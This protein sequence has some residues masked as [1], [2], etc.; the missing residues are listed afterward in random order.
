MVTHSPARR[1][2]GGALVPVGM[3]LLTGCT[4][5]AP[6]PSG[7]DT[8]T[9]TTQPSQTSDATSASSSAAGIGST[10]PSP[11]PTSVRKDPNAPANQCATSDL[12]VSVRENEDGNGLSHRGFFVALRN[13]GDTECELRGAPGVSLVGRGDGTQLGAA[14][15]RTEV[16]I[17]PT[18]EV[19]PGGYAVALL[20]TEEMDAHG[21]IFADGHGDD[22]KC[23]VAKADGYRI[24]PPH[25]Y[26]AVFV[27]QSGLY[28]CTT[29]VHW[30]SIA[31]V[32]PANRVNGFQP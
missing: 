29:Q 16:T 28:A 19:A 8:V 1:V 18:V 5:P 12:A 26:Q 11:S 6:S 17:P 24:Y 3:A 14:A 2:V 21:G 10:A 9:V 20:D 4:S 31:E 25:S 22:P 15:E 27:K 13:T 7:G 30:Q 23:K 32:N